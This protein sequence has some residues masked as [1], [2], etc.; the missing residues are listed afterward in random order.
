MKHLL[1]SILLLSFCSSSFAQIINYPD[2]SVAPNLN[3]GGDALINTTNELQLRVNGESQNGWAIHS[4]N[5]PSILFT[6][7]FDFS[8]GDQADQLHFVLQ[9]TADSFPTAPLWTNSLTVTL[10]HWQNTGNIS[11]NFVAVSVNDSAGAL[12]YNHEIDVT[13]IDI[14]DGNVHNAK[15][16]YDGHLLNVYFE[17]SV[18][19]AASFALDLSVVSPT[20]HNSQPWL[21]LR[22]NTGTPPGGAPGAHTIHSWTA[23]T[24]PP[25]TLYVDQSGN[26][27]YTHIQSAIDGSVN[28]DSVIVRDG[29]YFEHIN[30]NGKAITLKSENGA[31]TTIIDGSQSGSVVTI[32]S[33]EGSD[34]V[35]DGFTVTNG[36]AGS[37]N[38]GGMFCQYSSPTL[39]NCTFTNNT[40]LYGGGGV[41][42]GSSSPIL[43]DCT[44]TNNTANDGGGGLACWNNSSPTLENCTFT[45]N[46]AD[47]Q[48]GGMGSWFDSNPTMENCTF[49][50]CSSEYGAGIYIAGS[51]SAII[52][53]CTIK[54]C[55]AVYEGGGLYSDVNTF[56]LTL[57]NC[58]FLDNT[59]GRSAGGMGSSGCSPTL[60][61]CTFTNNSC[62][63]DGGG[64]W[65]NAGSEPTLNN[66][67]FTNNT[68]GNDGGA[69]SARSDGA[70]P[71][72][73]L[74]SCTIENNTAINGGGV[75]FTGAFGAIEDCLFTD[76]YASHVGGG[77]NLQDSSDVVMNN[78]QFLRNTC[79]NAGGAIDV[80][81]DSS[82]S[83]NNSLFEGNYTT[84]TTVEFAHVLRVGANS[85]VTLNNT[86]VGENGFG[87]H[88]IYIYSG[89]GASTGTMR[90]SIYWPSASASELDPSVECKY[91]CIRDGG[92]QILGN[93]NSDPLFVNAS[94]GDYRLQ[95]VDTGHASDS[96]CIDTGDPTITPFGTTRIDGFPD[97]GVIDMGYRI[98]VSDIDTDYDGLIDDIESVLGTGITDQ[99]TDDDGLSDGEEYHSYLT[100][101]LN[102]DSDLDGLQDGTEIGN[103]TFWTGN[104]SNGISGTDTSINIP[105]AD[106]S[107]T[108]DPLD[109]DT[110]NDGLMDGQE[111]VNHDGQ[112]LGIELDPNDFDGD[113]DGL[114][115]GLELGL[116][117]PNGNDTDMAVFVADADP[118]TTTRATLRDT[119]GGSIHDGLE[120]ANRNGRIDAGEIDPRDASDD[121]VYLKHNGASV[122]GQT[123]LN[124][125][126]CEPGSIMV[127]CYS[128]LG[129]GPTVFANVTL[130]LSQP[131]RQLPIIHIDSNGNGALGPLPVPASVSVGDQA[132]FQGVQVSIFGAST[133][134]T[135]TNMT[136]LTIQ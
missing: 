53:N 23:D 2:F 68:A 13:S 7:E 132:W 89:S 47:D 14:D 97:S 46:A 26:G 92:N 11:D 41:W 76:N 135:T 103:D 38:G 70:A 122:G 77:I 110:D 1:T 113:N 108:T 17:G 67:T 19:P 73:N 95:H 93:I 64:M 25:R 83:I 29:T 128:L 59:A 12:V 125:Y 121:S 21:G 56:S 58:T 39:E 65:F 74:N 123:T 114:G 105:D 66:C 15:F 82:V 81:S 30:F 91:S 87:N 40:A 88:L 72:L 133:V 6:T 116:A 31:A 79:D 4:V 50:D 111:D 36:T 35:F 112:F 55:S 18:V 51:A 10:D 85:D 78:S 86:T 48:G 62:T 131:I 3:I 60:D 69:I 45:N 94:T 8:I 5:F 101:P 33:G 104:P 100:D 57:D 37:G 117:V 24:M 80:W 98:P 32:E 9:S 129:P 119:D 42:C 20:L 16:E 22:A 120:D 130:D 84:S 27:D 106:P 44:F 134:L 90:N 34:S 127:L 126:A 61:N 99:D 107:T 115:D 124:V 54:N 43:R 118:S 52:T 75:D 102:I 71:T 63:L 49:E 109:D 136:L 28:G 96:P